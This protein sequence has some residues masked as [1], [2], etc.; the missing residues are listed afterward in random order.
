M[1]SEK[2]PHHEALE[3]L[4]AEHLRTQARCDAL[5]AVLT[6]LAVEAGGM[7]LQQA[8]DLLKT[9]YE[10]AYQRRLEFVEDI[11]PGLAGDLDNRPPMP[12]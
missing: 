4:A 5:E 3:A 8:L 11:D 10:K 9:Y 1:S 6:A 12:E 7:S 2:S